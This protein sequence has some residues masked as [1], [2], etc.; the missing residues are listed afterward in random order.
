VK[1]RTADKTT[2]N[3]HA[4]VCLSGLDKK[5][6]RTKKGEGRKETPKGA[7]SGHSMEVVPWGKKET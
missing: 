1:N 5:K 6:N 7:V 2:K 3:E 4:Q